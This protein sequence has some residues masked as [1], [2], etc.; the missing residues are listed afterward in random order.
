MAGGRFGRED[1]SKLINTTHMVDRLSAYTENN[2][3]YMKCVDLLKVATTPPHLGW[4][5][6]GHLISLLR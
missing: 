5:F 1:S 2:R 4:P 3:C 6:N